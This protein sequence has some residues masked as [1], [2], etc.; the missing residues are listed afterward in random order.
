M[1]TM[2][3]I[4]FDKMI[5]TV[6]EMFAFVQP[7]DPNMPVA[8]EKGT[9]RLCFYLKTL[10]FQLCVLIAIVGYVDKVFLY[11]KYIKYYFRFLV[12]VGFN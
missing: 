3:K 7:Q 11:I 5:R 1:R 4:T 12:L 6:P 8:P 2:N 9:I 10:C